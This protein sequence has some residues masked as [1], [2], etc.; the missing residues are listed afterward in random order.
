MHYPINYKDIPDTIEFYSEISLLHSEAESYLKSFKWCK[1]IKSSSL[2][3]NLGKVF[4][5]FLFEIE[6]I[7]SVGDNFLWLIVGDIPPMYLDIFGPK[8]TKEAVEDYIRLAADWIIKV[9]SR[10]SVDRCY[11]F[12]ASPTLESA[13]LF[14]KKVLFMKRTL[15]DNIENIQIKL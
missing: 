8:T 5:I 13:E 14:A 6:N 1:E 11:P 2:Y 9:N 7:S 12:D 10:E 15:L 3:T 4:C